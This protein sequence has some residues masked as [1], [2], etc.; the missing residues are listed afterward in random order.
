MTMN[1]FGG[2][3]NADDVQDTLIATDI[4]DSMACLHES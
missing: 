1:C 3:R 2:Y 4:S